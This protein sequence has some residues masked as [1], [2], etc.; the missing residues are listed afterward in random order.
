MAKFR[1]KVEIRFHSNYIEVEGNN[2]RV[3]LLSKP[4]KGKANIELV[5]KLAKYF[6]MP[7]SR[8]K[9]VSGQRSRRKIIE[10]EYEQSHEA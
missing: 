7:S 2:I 1:Y 8:I 6:K 9:I 4:E 10:I 3:G 5:K